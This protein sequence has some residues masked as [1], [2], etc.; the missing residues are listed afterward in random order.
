MI[1]AAGVVAESLCAPGAEE[2]ASGGSDA[3]RRALEES[4]SEMLGREKVNEADG[5]GEIA[6]DE[7][8]AAIGEGAAREVD[9]GNCASCASTSAATALAR[10]ADVVTQK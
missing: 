4:G 7:H 2:N 5:L 9:A 3:I 6:R 10:R 8:A 1:G